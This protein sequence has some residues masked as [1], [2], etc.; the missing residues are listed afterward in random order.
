MGHVP[1]SGPQGSLERLSALTRRRAI[2]ILYI[3]LNNTNP[4]LDAGSDEAAAIRRAGLEIAADGQ[5]LAL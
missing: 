4:A 3:H 2:R 1:I 5:E